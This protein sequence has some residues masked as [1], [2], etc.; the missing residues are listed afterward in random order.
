MYNLKTTTKD[1][2]E[3]KLVH[4][5]VEKGNIQWKDEKL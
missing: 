3:N 5:N 1:E 2:L 4:D